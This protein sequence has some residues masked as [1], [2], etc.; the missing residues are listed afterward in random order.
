MCQA[1]GCPHIKPFHPFLVVHPLSQHRWRMSL[2]IYLVSLL[3]LAW[4]FILKFPSFLSSFQNWDYLL[5]HPS[6]RSELSCNIEQ[7]A[8]ELLSTSRG[9]ESLEGQVGM[10]SLTVLSQKYL[11]KLC[12]D[13]HIFEISIIISVFFNHTLSKRWAGWMRFTKLLVWLIYLTN[14]ECLLDIETQFKALGIKW[15]K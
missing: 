15:P 4:G 9:S 14:I 1:C 8:R 12:S 7:R 3:L 11:T 10:S 6:L 13:N 5:S 2:P